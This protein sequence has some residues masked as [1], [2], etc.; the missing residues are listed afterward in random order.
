MT[1]TLIFKN[2]T[3]EK[4]KA[5]PIQITG[6]AYYTQILRPGKEGK[7]ARGQRIPPNYTISVVPDEEYMELL[8]F[9]EV[10]LKTPTESIPGPHV[11]PRVSVDKIA[12]AAAQGKKGPKK[13]R[14]I[15]EDQAEYDND[16]PL[17]GNGSK[18]TLVMYAIP[19]MY[20]LPNLVQVN[21]L[22]EY[23]PEDTGESG[24]DLISLAYSMSQDPTPDDLPDQD[25]GSEAELN[26]DLPEDMALDSVLAAG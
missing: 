17:V 18:V 12:E 15:G 7:N 24:A 11:N 6:T 3:Y 19:G 25:P 21:E 9:L 8:E 10:T 26:D 16:S 2:R 1:D 20:G 4:G 5:G 13:P 23:I 22:V 14:L